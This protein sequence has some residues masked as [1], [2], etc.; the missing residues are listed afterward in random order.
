LQP[1]RRRRF[2]TTHRRS[3]LLFG[4]EAAGDAR[5]STRSPFFLADSSLRRRGCPGKAGGLL[6]S[7]DS[8]LGHRAQPVGSGCPFKSLTA[9][10]GA[11]KAMWKERRGRPPVSEGTLLFLR[12]EQR[13]LNGRW[14]W[15]GAG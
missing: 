10:F 9:L 8:V 2:G 1:L 11:R 15:S 14:F 12:D 3:I 5:S 7:C 4:G 6:R 13:L